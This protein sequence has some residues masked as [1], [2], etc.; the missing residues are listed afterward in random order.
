LRNNF[1]LKLFVDATTF[2]PASA[3][4][5]KVPEG[6]RPRRHRRET[7]EVASRRS[8]VPREAA[9]AS[10]LLTATLF[11]TLAPLTFALLSVAILLLSALLS[12]TGR[13]ARFVWILLC[14]YDAFIY[15]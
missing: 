14:V 3:A 8:F 10:A 15:D 6:T 13:L 4:I 1:I 7:A 12:G 11:F 2:K 9:L 5:T